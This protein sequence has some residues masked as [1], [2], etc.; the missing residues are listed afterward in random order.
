MYRPFD[1]SSARLE[2]GV[3]GLLGCVVAWVRGWVCVFGVGREFGE[4]VLRVCSGRMRS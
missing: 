3:A 1:L 4:G 2:V